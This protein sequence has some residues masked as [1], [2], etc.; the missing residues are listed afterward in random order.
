MKSFPQW[1]KKF[2][3]VIKAQKMEQWTDNLEGPLMGKSRSSCR[4]FSL[5]RRNLQ[6]NTNVK[7]WIFLFVSPLRG[8]AFWSVLS[9]S[10][11]FQREEEKN[12]FD[13]NM[14]LHFN[15]RA[16]ILSCPCFEM[17]LAQEDA[18]KM[19][20]INLSFWMKVFLTEQLYVC[21]A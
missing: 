9:S 17:Y 18:V 20:Y 3:M 10:L 16:C 2:Q 1:K 15:F 12:N 8:R 21:P 5:C 7:W 13:T 14:S 6:Q 4:F 11:L 19:P